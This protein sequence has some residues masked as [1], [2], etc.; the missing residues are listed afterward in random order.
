[1]TIRNIQAVVF[2]VKFNLGVLSLKS[3][4]KSSKKKSSQKT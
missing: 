3:L 1:M 2:V 4:E